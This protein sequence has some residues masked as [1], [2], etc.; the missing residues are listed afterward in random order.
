M[1][2]RPPRPPRPQRAP[3]LKSQMIA[4]YK[5]VID[6]GQIADGEEIHSRVEMAVQWNVSDGTVKL[7]R[8]ALTSEGY[9]RGEN[10]RA[11]YAIGPVQRRLAAEQSSVVEQG[12]WVEQSSGASAAEAA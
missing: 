9:I 2:P 5:R 8:Q 4:Y 6:L 1:T 10:G 7:V 12:S 3:T 11:T